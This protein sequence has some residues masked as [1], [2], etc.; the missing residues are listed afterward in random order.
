MWSIR[1]RLKHMVPARCS[2]VRRRT[3]LAFLALAALALLALSS[4]GTRL[5]REEEME[6]R[7]AQM[8]AHLQ[9]LDTLY[10]ARQVEVM[11]MQSKLIDFGIAEQSEKIIGPSTTMTPEVV[12]L[13]KNLT[14]TKAAS[15]VDPKNLQPQTLPFIYQLMPHL[16]DDAYSLRPAYHMRGSRQLVQV[17]IGI[18]TVKRDKESY[19]LVTL[20][21][22]ITGMTE[23]DLDE[24]VIIVMVGEADLEFVINTAKQIETMFPKEVESGLIEVISP[25]PSY[26]PD[27]DSIEP[28]LGDSSKRMRWRTKQNLDTIFLMAYAQSRGTFYLMLEDDVIA[29][30]N[31]MQDIKYFAATT[32]IKTP[33]WF[34][35]EYCVFGGIGKL[36]RSADLVHF[37]TYVQ[38]FYTNMPIDWLLE[39]YLA[40]KVCSIYKT[41]KECAKSKTDIRPKYKSSLFQHIGL[42]SSLKGKIQKVQHSH[43][44]KLPGFYPHENPPLESIHNDIEEKADHTIRRAYNGET[45]FWGLKPKKG[46]V[47]EFV[48]QKPIMLERYTFRSGNVDHASDKF[49]DTYVEVQPVAGNYSVVDSFDEFGLA[50]GSLKRDWG[51]LNAIRL[52]VNRDSTFWVILSEIE[53]KPYDQEDS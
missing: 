50:D 19:L 44:G 20:T 29:K 28:T 41:S 7:L 23:G 13:L 11:H 5:N 53:L 21:H 33:Q 8:Q 3:L 49:Y 24:T 17:V 9:F 30:K 10:R 40:D 43:Y 38:L 52:R 6:A 36:F 35:I 48:F 46:D 45:F 32:T 26:Y 31:Y 2:G 22:L 37:I 34:F 47:I 15:G 12:Q 25:S 42:Y 14:G 18:P 51:P 4:G 39:S 27:F 16:L 1:R